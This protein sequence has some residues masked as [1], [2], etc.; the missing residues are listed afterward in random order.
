MRTQVGSTS[1]FRCPHPQSSPGGKGRSYGS[2]FGIVTLRLRCKSMHA[3][4][5]DIQGKSVKIRE[6]VCIIGAKVKDTSQIVKFLL[7]CSRGS[8]IVPPIRDNCVAFVC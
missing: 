5:T 8:T 2:G 7:T 6:Y 1:H 4:K 3:I